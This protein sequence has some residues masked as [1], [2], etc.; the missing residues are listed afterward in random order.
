MS[1]E[2]VLQAFHYET[3][4]PPKYHEQQHHV[5]LSLIPYGCSVVHLVVRFTDNGRRCPRRGSIRGT[6]GRKRS[7]FY[8]NR[9][10]FFWPKKARFRGY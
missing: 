5:H 8:G 2:S 10:G 7:P 9:N 3:F 1:Q 4:R 6:Q